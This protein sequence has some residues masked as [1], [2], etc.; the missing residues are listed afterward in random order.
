[1]VTLA[2]PSGRSFSGTTNDDGRIDD[3]SGDV[4]LIAGDYAFPGQSW[5][6]I[7]STVFA[8]PLQENTVLPL[9]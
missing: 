6:P 3:W 2:H 1:M 8:V 5:E 4:D 9:P 7:N